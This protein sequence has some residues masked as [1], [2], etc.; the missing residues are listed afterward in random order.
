M[1]GAIRASD[2]DRERVVAALHD[3]VGTGRLSLDEFS[4]RAALAYRAQTVGELQALT[5]DLPVGA[6]TPPAAPDR[7]W[8]PVLVA[9]VLAV[10]LGSSLLFLLDATASH[11]MDQMMTRMRP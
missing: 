2:A 4:D 6:P 11:A 8:M 7:G 3:Q 10:V 9:V 1:T 5:H